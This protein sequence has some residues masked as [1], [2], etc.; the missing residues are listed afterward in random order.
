MKD[1]VFESDNWAIQDKEFK[2]DVIRVNTK[3]R[4]STSM[5]DELEDKHEDYFPIPH[6]EWCDLLSRMA[7]K[8]HRKRDTA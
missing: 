8:D 2:E 6:E 3:D 5:Q 7:I 1:G 4:L